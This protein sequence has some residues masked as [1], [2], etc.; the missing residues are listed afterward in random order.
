M[1]DVERLPPPR[2]QK[3]RLHN[4]VGLALQLIGL[5]VE[6]FISLLVSLYHVF[7]P[8]PQKDIS[9]QVVLITGTGRGIGRELALEFAR[10]GCKVA[11]A[12]I[13]PSLNA[14]TIKLVNE[15]V[16]ESCTG[17]Q[18]DVGN[19]DSVK[20]LRKQVLTDL[21]RVDI[22]VNNAGI[23]A[24][25]GINTDI[26]PRMIENMAK[27]NFLSHIW[28]CKTFLPEMIE[29]NSGHIVCIASMSALAGLANASLYAACKW[30]ITGL[31]ESLR[32]ELRLNPKNK[33][34]TSVV[35]PYFVN[36][37]AEYVNN[38]TCRV[39]ELSAERCAKEIV[40]GMREDQVIFSVPREQYFAAALI[41]ILPQK[42]RDRFMDIFHAKV[43][44]LN[45]EDKKKTA[46][47]KILAG[48][49]D[50]KTK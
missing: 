47:Y 10:K 20:A 3:R 25:G 8:L 28:M 17:Y 36:T 6:L 7:V 48:E 38:W 49:F 23:V 18:V 13:Q 9:G 33:I 14:E 31:M 46:S 40:R 29:M 27:V 34:K 16:P 30:A 42:V 15:L 24:G 26:E 12:E 50:A 37:S 2:S 44:K 11:C 4:P 19:L 22:L 5:L 41:K 1:A 35:C 39:P 32:D 43:N 45:V 21:G